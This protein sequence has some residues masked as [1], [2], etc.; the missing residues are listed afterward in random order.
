MSMAGGWIPRQDWRVRLLVWIG[1]AGLV[2][3]VF[4][5]VVRGGGLLTDQTD[6]ASVGLS[7]L[8]TAVVALTF[9]PARRLLERVATR[10]MH[11]GRTVPYD[12]LTD[13]ADSVTGSFPADELPIRMAMMLA[14]AT[15]AA[16]AQVWLFVH[17]RLRLAATWPGE[18]VADDWAPDVREPSGSGSGRRVVAIQHAGRTL[19][20]LT[21]QQR[22][23]SPLTP[24]EERLLSSLAAQAGMALRNAQ[25]RAE[26][27]QQLTE[28][29]ERAEEL[30]ASRARLVAT[31]DQ[32]RRRL[33]RDIHD[34]AQQHLVALGV[35]LRLARLLV[36]RAPDRATQLVAEQ[37]VAAE[38]AMET[39]SRLANGIYPPVLERAGLEPA[40]RAAAITS[41][42]PVEVDSALTGRFPGEVEAS[43][44]FCG[45]EAL[46]NAVKHSGATRITV[47]LSS[48]DGGHLEVA[49]DGRGLPPGD[50]S[51]SGLTNMR[52]RIESVG[53][54]LSV[55]SHGGH[56]TTV[57][58][59]VPEVVAVHPGGAAAR[60]ASS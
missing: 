55:D 32:E 44:Y 43:L 15:G 58:A 14:N 59:W 33:E 5:I 45:L 31:Q 2:V 34:G 30:Q 27:A 49:D 17:G 54:T 11:G 23:Q 13:F 57:R 21:L 28:L 3:A 12:L 46:Q 29:S 20:A 6:R 22:D 7:V 1:M 19:G 16:K 9:E 53:G 60:G 48:S 40:L 50:P 47:R 25:L 18:I 52:D 38:D 8:A 4:V 36:S 24:V 35:N 37:K 51:G 10:W 39:V 26:L 41:P 42:I 56:G